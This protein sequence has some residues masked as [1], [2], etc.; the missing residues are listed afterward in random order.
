MLVMAESFAY[1]PAVELTIPSPGEGTVQDT[2]GEP[3]VHSGGAALQSLLRFLFESDDALH[4]HLRD[5]EGVGR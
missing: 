4:S 5:D 3:R 1:Y 2:L